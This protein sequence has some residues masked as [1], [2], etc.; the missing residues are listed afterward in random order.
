MAVGST[1]GTVLIIDPK[2]LMATFNF[3]DRDAEVSC[4]KFSPD[5]EL[6]AVGH[7]APSCDVLI[8]SIKNHFEKFNVLR[9]SPARVISI[10]FSMNCRVL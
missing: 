1:N 4:L 9:G 5:T 7:G 8:Y 3:K 6:L 2:T 10:D